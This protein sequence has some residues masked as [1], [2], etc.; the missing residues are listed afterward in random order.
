MSPTRPLISDSEQR[1]AASPEDCRSFRKNDGRPISVRY[2]RTPQ[3]HQQDATKTATGTVLYNSRR[4]SDCDHSI[5]PDQQAEWRAVYPCSV[6]SPGDE[7]ERR[8]II[9]GTR[10]LWMAFFIAS[11]CVLGIANEWAA[12]QSNSAGLRNTLSARILRSICPAF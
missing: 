12:N 11:S 2:S 6:Q 4:R 10:K 1:I 3:N 7:V 5:L 9:S 8:C